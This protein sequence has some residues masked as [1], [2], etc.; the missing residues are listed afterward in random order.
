L[1]DPL[2]LNHILVLLCS[3][4]AKIG[5]KK[6]KWSLL[7]NVAKCDKIFDELLK[8]DNVKLSHTIPPIDVIK[9]RAYC[10]W[11]NSFSHAI[12]DCNVFRGQKQSS[13]DEGWLKFLDIQ[14]G[15]QSFPVNTWWEESSG[16][17][18]A[19]NKNKCDN[20]VIGNPHG[21]YENTRTL[22]RKVVVEKTLDGKE[23]LKI[24]IKSISVGGVKTEQETSRALVACVYQTV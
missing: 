12:N 20:I 18:E 3:S 17:P 11:H 10:K 15:S 13:I 21:I 19:I 6:K 7:F 16:S 1:F 8:S 2:R 9:K 24:T 5:K 14:L 23:A 22:A 4:L